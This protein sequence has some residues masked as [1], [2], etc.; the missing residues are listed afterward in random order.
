METDMTGECETKTV[1]EAID[2]MARSRGDDVFLISPETAKTLTFGELQEQ[3]KAISTRL[4]QAGLSTGDK[5]AFLL[6][7]GLFTIQLFLG[8]MYSGVVSVPLNVRAGL[9][10]LAYT[11]D[12]CDAKAVFVE[13]QYLALAS[14]ALASVNRPVQLITVGA[15]AFAT[16]YSQ[17]LGDVSFAAPSPEDVSLLM[18]TSG[19]V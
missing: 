8:T 9:S 7:N 18:Y 17:P 19:S 16:D 6:D 11:L 2:Q 14:E 4:R 13:E 15:E 10:Q 1:R 3:S 12:H 5:A